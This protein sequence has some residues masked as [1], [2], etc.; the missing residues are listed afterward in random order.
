LGLVFVAAFLGIFHRRANRWPA[1]VLGIPAF[2]GN[3]SRYTLA[4]ED[5][6]PFA[7]IFHFWAALFLLY[8][9]V[10]ILI[11]VYQESVVSID[12]VFGAFC[13]YLL[14][15]VA[16]AHLYCIL[17]SAFPGSF[18]L[19]QKR[20]EDSSDQEHMLFFLLTYFSYGALTTAG[21]GDLTAGSDPARS[22]AMIETILGQFYLAGLIAELI[23][24]RVSQTPA[25]AG[26]ASGVP[27]PTPERGPDSL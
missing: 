18:P 16:F 7:A 10:V 12:G 5:R 8:T 2:A 24:K 23:G 3:W 19:V 1:Y 6:M 9:I 22:L 14:L 4:A 13:G 17:E 25:S 11:T 26:T 15:G 20:L 27:R 21:A